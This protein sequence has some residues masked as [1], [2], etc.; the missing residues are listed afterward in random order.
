MGNADE[1]MAPHNVYPCWGVDRWVAIAVET[2][3][4]FAALARAIGRPELAADP[5]FVDADSRKKNEVV[6][7]EIIAVWTRARDR[8]FVAN[9]LAGEGIAAAPSRDAHDLFHDPHLRAR[10]VFVEVDHP[11]VG[12]R[13][14]MGA[15][16]IMSDGNLQARPAPDLGQDNDH[17]FQQILG[18]SETELAA[19][20]RDGIIQ[21]DR[22]RILQ[23][24]TSNAIVGHPKYCTRSEK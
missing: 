10:G 24:L 14:F 6:L 21:I 16:W 8:D 22:S 3:E 20:E 5:R 7:D 18:L 9:T 23:K 13:Q 2:D 19:L 15:P 4:E 17:V 12:P 11:G 1:L